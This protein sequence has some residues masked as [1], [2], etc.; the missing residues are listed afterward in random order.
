MWKFQR[1]RVVRNISGVSLCVEI[2][3]ARRERRRQLEVL[4]LVAERDARTGAW[5]LAHSAA[6][7]YCLPGRGGRIVLTTTAMSLLRDEELVAVV[8][9]ERAHVRQRHDIVLALARAAERSLGWLPG[10]R[11]THEEQRRLVEMIADDAAARRSTRL[12]VAGAL[13]HLADGSAPRPA[14]GA[15]DTVAAQRVERLLAHRQ[16]LGLRGRL[17]VYLTIG[18]MLAAPV[19]VAVAPAFTADRLRYC[20]VAVAG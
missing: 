14:L 3:R 19:L 9:H 2:V 11:G 18:G 12:A 6:A 13:L 1:A 15:A 5:V 17:G 20:L 4:D 10:V 7:A 8:T 16:P